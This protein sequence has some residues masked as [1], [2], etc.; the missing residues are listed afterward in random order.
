MPSPRSRRR[1]LAKRGERRAAKWGWR[2]SPWWAKASSAP[3]CRLSLTVQCAVWFRKYLASNN[4]WLAAP[5]SRHDN[6]ARSKAVIGSFPPPMTCD[7]GRTASEEAGA[8][9]SNYVVALGSAGHTQRGLS[10]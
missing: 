7:Q 4:A 9:P 8:V 2:P 6:L 3:R 5:S 10:F 1:S